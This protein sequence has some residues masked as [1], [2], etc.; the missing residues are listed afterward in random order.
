MIVHTWRIESS[1]T[2]NARCKMCAIQEEQKLQQATSVPCKLMLHSSSWHD[3]CLQTNWTVFNVC[4]VKIT[5]ICLSARNLHSATHSRYEAC[6]K[7]NM[8]ATYSFPQCEQPIHIH[9]HDSIVLF[10]NCTLDKVSIKN[11]ASWQNVTWHESCIAILSMQL[12]CQ[13]HTVQMYGIQLA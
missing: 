5:V 13:W 4:T 2:T 11:R 1:G 9:L 12:W 10:N 7:C 6:I 8:W 3:V